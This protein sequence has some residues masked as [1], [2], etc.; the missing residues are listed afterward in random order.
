[1]GMGMGTWYGYLVW[2]LGMGT[3]YGYGM[4]NTGMVRRQVRKLSRKVEQGRYCR[5]V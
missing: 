1:M 5:N 2:V 3:W 4:N